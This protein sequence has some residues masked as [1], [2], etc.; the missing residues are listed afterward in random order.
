[1]GRRAHGVPGPEHRHLPQPAGISDGGSRHVLRRRHHLRHSS[2]GAAVLCVPLWLRLCI[3]HD[4]QLRTARCTRPL[5]RLS[6]VPDTQLIGH[7]VQTTHGL[8][9]RRA[10]P[11]TVT[12]PRRGKHLIFR[13]DLMHGVPTSIPGS[14]EGGA[15]GR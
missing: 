5:W 6:C 10:L 2:T 3:V 8:L 1:M 7:L 12:D 13:G 4:W 14:S 15:P 11:A 9:T